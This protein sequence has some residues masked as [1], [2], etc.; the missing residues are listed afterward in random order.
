MAEAVAWATTEPTDM[1]VACDE[2]LTGHWLIGSTEESDSGYMGGDAPGAPFRAN[3]EG[4]C[5][6]SCN[7]PNV[8]LPVSTGTQLSSWMEDHAEFDLFKYSILFLQK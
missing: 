3:N 8:F 4:P 1:G 6:F 2:L 7:C 5:K